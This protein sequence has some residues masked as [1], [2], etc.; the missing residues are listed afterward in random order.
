[1]PK[2]PQ[3]QHGS[4]IEAP[5]H[6]DQSGRDRFVPTDVIGV[7]VAVQLIQP[8]HSTCSKGWQSLHQFVR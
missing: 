8:E 1:M 4:A 3:N 5:Q 6:L 2:R 7:Q